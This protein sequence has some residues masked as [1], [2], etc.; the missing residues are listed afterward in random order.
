M[1]NPS[2]SDRLP[3]GSFR[4]HEVRFSECEWKKRENPYAYYSVRG[5]RIETKYAILDVD[6]AYENWVE[7]SPRTG[8]TQLLVR[9]NKRPARPYECRPGGV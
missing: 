3:E 8:G 4:K 5:E 9:A 1:P 2:K 7:R 6:A